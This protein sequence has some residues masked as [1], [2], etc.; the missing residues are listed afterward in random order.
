MLGVMKIIFFALAGLLIA[1][2][3]PASIGVSHDGGLTPL[4]R[5]MQI[6]AVWVLPFVGAIVT[7]VVRRSQSAAKLPAVSPDA[8][9]SNQVSDA[10]DMMLAQS[11][12][13]DNAP[14]NS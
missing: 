6:L 8:I 9:G 7:F 13:A 3:V 11:V 1:T 10:L 12:D 2:N 14:H 4:Q 5:R